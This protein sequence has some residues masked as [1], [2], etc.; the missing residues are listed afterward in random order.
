M[1]RGNVSK[2]WNVM[3]AVAWGWALGALY[4]AILLGSDIAHSAQAFVE[5]LSVAIGC[6]VIFALGAVLRNLTFGRRPSGKAP[7]YR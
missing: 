1:G 5:M 2:G 4:M 6:A 3:H 7:E